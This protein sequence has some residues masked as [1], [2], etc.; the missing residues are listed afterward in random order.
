MTP[1]PTFARRAVS[2]VTGLLLV[3]LAAG[4][5]MA[6]GKPGETPPPA[7]PN[8]SPA[9]AATPAATTGAAE[10]GAVDAAADGLYSCEKAR[11]KFKVNLAADIELKDLIT[12][13]FSFTCKN[14]IYS[15]EISGRVPKVTIKSPEAMTAQQAWRVFLVALRSMKLTV[16]PRGNILEIVEDSTAKDKPLAIYGKGVPGS[17]DEIVRVVLRPDNLGVDDLAS[18]LTELKSTNGIVKGVPRAG[19]VLV[20][21]YASN[22][23]RMAQLMI[24]VDQEVAGERLYMV[25]VKYAEATAMVTTLNEI[26]GIKDA[27]AGG[28]AAAPQPAVGGSRAQRRQARAEAAANAEPAPAAEGDV[29]AVE[30]AVPSKLI[31]DERTNAIIMLGSEPAYL[32]VKALVARLDVNVDGGGGG[33][34]HVHLLENA[35]AEQL[36]TT[37]QAVISG[38]TQSPAQGGRPAGNRNAPPTQGG[39]PDGGGAAFEGQVR[40]THDKPTN[41]I[42]VVSSEKDF[43]AVR[44]VINQLD[45]ARPQVYIEATIV[46]VNVNNSRTIGT[47]FHGGLPFGDGH[48]LLGGAQHS[49]FSSLNLATALAATGLIGGAVG[50]PLEGAEE[51]L[52]TTIPSFAVLFQALANSGMTNVLSSPHLLTKDNEQAKISVGENIPYQSALVGGGAAGA[53]AGAFFPTQ[54]IQR[55]DVALTLE[56]TPHIGASEMVSL[57][58]NLEISDIAQRN[59]EGLGPSWAKRTIT[60][61]VVVRDQQSVVL[62]GLMADKVGTSESKVPLLGD[63]PVLG[64]LFKFSVKTKEKRNLLVILTPYIIRDQD[65]LE[66]IVEKRTREQQEFIRAQSAFGDMKYRPEIDYRRKRGLLAQIDLTVRRAE[67]DE[68]ERRALEDQMLGFPDGPIDYKASA[69]AAATPAAPAE[70]APAEPKSE[71]GN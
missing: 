15:A 29:A 59:F 30:A 60:D 16:V 24:S 50:A 20:T 71:G 9:G 35:D 33:R 6:Q 53:A 39:G 69:E 55:Q 44:D 46:E 7:S 63:I 51:L 32:R 65:D 47:S 45:V 28:G 25:R 5:V 36:G 62:G 57:D 52:G 8:P 37:L 1:T 58:L 41:S 13:A 10:G 23:S 12:W 21:D 54:S 19:I 64:H 26:L 17:S 66:Q 49:S 27:P 40:V 14:F 43:L 67:R 61:K 31:A 42:V 22:V 70:P 2:L 18:V 56:V 11:G 48:V 38:I 34:I 68:L 4:P 3:G